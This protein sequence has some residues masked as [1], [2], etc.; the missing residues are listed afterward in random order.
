[1]CMIMVG[2]CN[3]HYNYYKE[4]NIEKNFLDIVSD[5]GVNRE[6]INVSIPLS[7][8]SSTPAPPTNSQAVHT[9]TSSFDSPWLK[10][11]STTSIEDYSSEVSP[12]VDVPDLALDIF[13]LFYTP[14]CLKQTEVEYNHY[15]KEVTD[16]EKYESWKPI[17]EADLKAFFGFNILMG[18]NQLPSIED[19]WKQY[20]VYHYYTIADKISRRR[21]REI[22]RY[23]HFVDNSTLASP[24]SPEYD[25]LGKNRPL[26]EHMQSRCAALYNPSKQ[27]AIDEAMIKFQ[28]R[29]SLKQYMPQKPIKRGI[30]VWVL[31]DSTNGFFSRPEVYT[32]KKE[33]A[34]RGLGARVVKDLSCDF[35]GKWHHLYFDNFFT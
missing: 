15:A 10:S 35:Q 20:P 14:Q 8:L 13:Y 19:Y 18:L 7:V 31:A 30:K 28:G 12:T 23:L 3:K 16:P 6:E 26:L 17:D 27:L 4:H 11:F 34:E 1:M 33:H 21:Y 9:L 32:D 22:S 29:S 5:K 2:R 25:R 24:G